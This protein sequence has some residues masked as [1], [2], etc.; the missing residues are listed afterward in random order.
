MAAAFRHCGIDAEVLAPS[1]EESLELGR[2][3]TT[4][5][6]CLPAIV[7]AGDMVKKV[8]SKDF[9]RERSAFFMPGG[10]GPCRFGQ[11]NRLHRYILK[12]IG[13][14]DVP[15]LSPNQG[16]S[17]YDDFRNLEKDPTRL[18]WQGIVV[19][20][21]LVKTLHR[22]RPYEVN[23]GETDRVFRDCITRLTEVIERGGDLVKTSAE[24]ADAM[25]AVPVREE[26]RPLV[27]I[28]GEI[29]VRSHTL[30]NADVI[31]TL[32]SL[33][34]EV[35]LAGFI[36]WIYYTNYVRIRRNRW[37]R[38]FFAGVKNIL[39]QWV[40][41]TDERRL[42]GPFTD[43]LREAVET[44]TREILGEASPYIHDS[45]EG[46]CV[47]TVGK[48]ISYYH[49]H[50]SGVVNVMPFTC[51]PGNICAAL[52]KRVREDHEQV[53]VV[54]LAYDGQNLGGK[55]TRLEA[56]MHQVKEFH[57]RKHGEPRTLQTSTAA[58]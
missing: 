54:S 34:A 44:P 39:K 16:Q 49:H 22:V 37:Q 8:F 40:Q 23:P 35:D 3:Y 42:A 15:V 29:Y 36:E 57:R 28:V 20:D 21:L 45:F 58:G 55:L 6:E 32:E 4:G 33:G 48:S 12:E 18:A 5:K 47:L 26:D 50:A 46:E 25:K 41:K 27:G 31:R 43:L 14:E 51:M 38:D 52:L 24:L 9:D 10:S 7:T 30:S 11:Y 17:F 1:D 13:Y 56:F 19:V 2:R 53:P